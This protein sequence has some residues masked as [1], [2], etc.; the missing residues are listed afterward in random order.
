MK[1]FGPVF[2]FMALSASAADPSVL[3]FGDERI[4]VPPLSLAETLAQGATPMKP[5]QFGAG[6]PRY[7]NG[8]ESPPVSPN[9]VPR[10]TPSLKELETSR[11][12]LARTPRVSR[13]SG[14]PIIEPSETVDYKMRIIPPNPAIDFKLVI[15]DPGVPT[16]DKK[17]K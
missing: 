7:A 1:Y 2:A 17:A 11:L 6:V 15:I 16:D 10:S 13:S 5:S 4:G 3:K 8:A 12:G 9:L 14:M